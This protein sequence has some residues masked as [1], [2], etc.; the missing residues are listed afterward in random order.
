MY[1]CI[2]QLLKLTDFEESLLITADGDSLYVTGSEK[3]KNFLKDNQHIAEEFHKYCYGTY[4]DQINTYV[5]QNSNIM[6]TDIANL[7]L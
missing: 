2:Q 5:Q 7:Q 4:T 1:V 3:G 6:N